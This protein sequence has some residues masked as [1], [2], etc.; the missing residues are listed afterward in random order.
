MHAAKN[1]E[2][3]VFQLIKGNLDIMATA[4]DLALGKT[5]AA[6][7]KSVIE[8]EIIGV[9]LKPKV[10]STPT[11]GKKTEPKAD[12][13]VKTKTQHFKFSIKKDKYTYTHTSNSAEDSRILF[14]NFPFASL[15]STSDAETIDAAI[16]KNLRKISNFEKWPTGKG[17]YDEWVKYQL[18]K[19]KSKIITWV[20]VEKYN[21]IEFTIIKKYEEVIQSGAKPYTTQLHS[22][23][24]EV[25]NLFDTV[26][27]K[28][29]EYGKHLLFEMATG[30]FKFGPES[31]AAANWIVSA[32]GV[33]ELTDPN[34]EWIRLKIE[35]LLSYKTIGRLQNV[36]RA[37]LSKQQCLLADIDTIAN[38]FPTADMSMKL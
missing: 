4:E 21:D 10:K 26:F 28:N 32:E 33:W 19:F 20:G 8:E 12:L 36:P 22:M 38:G 5:I 7:I 1:L 18:G 29:P 15:L 17:N 31:E 3:I 24:A 2:D 23:E 16:L 27:R 13:I 25:N 6:N 9:T 14:F 11:Y 30:N 35:Q 37:S 34:C